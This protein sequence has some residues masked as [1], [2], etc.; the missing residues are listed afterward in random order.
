MENIHDL[1][2][3]RRSIRRFKDEPIPADDVKLIFEAGLMAPTSKSGRP[4]QFIAVEDKDMLRRLSECKPSYANAIASSALS[5]VVAV[6]TT[7]S[8]A[9]IEDASV[10]ATFMQ[11]QAQDLGLAS[12]WVQVRGRFA[13]NGLPSEEYVQEALGIPEECTPVCIIA[14]GYPEEQRKPQD[15]EKLKWEQVH[16]GKY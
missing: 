11:L 13:P 8:D 14:I 15:L 6:D 16:V 9:W 7:K 2:V 4:W 12:C 3:S 1:L 5:V 10:A